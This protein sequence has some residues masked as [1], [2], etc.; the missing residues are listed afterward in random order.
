[1]ET[2]T[3]QSAT[4]FVERISKLAHTAAGKPVPETTKESVPL[5]PI[6]IGVDRDHEQ[7]RE[8][9]LYRHGDKQWSVKPAASRFLLETALPGNLEKTVQDQITA[10]LKPYKDWQD[11]GRE[12]LVALQLYARL[13][14]RVFRDE[15]L[16]D[17]ANPQNTPDT[18]AMRVCGDLGL[19]C[20]WYDVIKGH[21]ESRLQEVRQDLKEAPEEVQLQQPGEAALAAFA[22]SQQQQPDAPSSAAAVGVPRH[23]AAAG[24]APAG[25][26]Q[27]LVVVSPNFCLPQQVTLV[28]TAD[29][30]IQQTGY[31]SAACL[32]CLRCT[33]VSP[34]FCLLQQVTLV[35][36]ES[37]GAYRNDDFHICDASG[38]TFFL[39]KAAPYSAS[40]RRQL[41]DACGTTFF[42]LKAAP[43]S[44][45][46]RRAL[47]DAYG[48]PCIHMERK[49]TS[50]RGSWQLLRSRDGLQLA[51]VKP[52]LSSFTPTI[53]VM[54]NDGDD[55]PDFII[56]GDFRAKSFAITQCRSNAVIGRVKK[57]S[58][59]ASVNA[60][61]MSQLVGAQKY[62]VSIEPGVDAAFVVALATLCDEIFHD[63]QR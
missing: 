53:K 9:F 22:T 1:M 3:K 4:G 42:L 16:W 17:V 39:L 36:Q 54:L 35:M 63:Q 29:L 13:N 24:H 61:F 31:V 6:Y 30:M 59:H 58:S 21:L 46:G 43:H 15:L 55:N 2:S 34:N 62:F 25:T 12:Q 47:L 49:L 18:Y 7:L 19:G 20:D 10:G 50:L 40:G 14:D 45:S 60:F 44:A 38:T 48:Q 41:L 26:A 27:Q 11:P 56:A 51:V 37:L 57:E 28:M 8:M 52:S 23:A 33:V 32:L 5:V